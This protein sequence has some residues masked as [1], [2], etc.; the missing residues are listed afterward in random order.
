MVLV[1]IFLYFRYDTVS[2]FK[3][4]HL[5]DS[6]I[7]VDFS[8]F[9]PSFLLSIETI[10]E[11]SKAIIGTLPV[12]KLLGLLR[13]KSPNFF[14]HIPEEWSAKLQCSDQAH[15]SSDYCPCAQ[16]D[17]AREFDERKKGK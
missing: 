17:E 6:K 13:V 9:N 16:M 10:K 14:V 4:L 5:M 11:I 15:F 3:F 7:A 8:D 12:E 1:N 2:R